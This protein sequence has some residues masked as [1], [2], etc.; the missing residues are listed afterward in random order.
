M[1]WIILYSLSFLV[2]PF[3]I[4]RLARRTAIG[5]VLSEVV[6]CYM[7]GILI[8]N[9]APYWL[10]AAEAEPIQN[11]TRSFTEVSVLL[12][13]PILL[14]LNYVLDW[15]RYTGPLLWAFGISCLSMALASLG[16]AWYFADTLPE[17][18]QAAGMLTGVFIG[19]TP[20]MVSIQRGLGVDEEVFLMLNATDTFCSGLYVI[21]LTA[22]GQHFF[23]LLLPPFRR[24]A[25]EVLAEAAL[26]EQAQNPS[27]TWK[28]ALWAT[29]ISIVVVAL[30]LA[31]GF[32]LADAEGKPNQLA[33]MLLLTA[34]GTLLS[35]SSKIRALK[36]GAEPWG[37][38]LLLIF[39]ISIGSMADFVK[40]MSQGGD[41]LL[42]TAMVVYGGLGL[43][44]L[45]AALARIDRDT[46]II[47][48]TAGIFG[49]PFV[50]QVGAAIRNHSLIAGGMALGVAGLAL[51]NYLGFALA[52][53]AKYLL[54]T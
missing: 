34:L 19:G 44:W 20:N 30:A 46:F 49:P 43:A 35:L 24:S 39:A 52:Q 15:L 27:G 2:L 32:G 23:G 38:Y 36:P 11:L 7:T 26:E 1:P 29:L 42:F 12:A 45:L 50:S 54:G 9:T 5:K 40:L 22:F 37:N 16:A 25:E 41:Y 53:L 28:Q 18:H 14:M 4:Q 8:G 13:I 51:G 21:G 3:F 10:P 48:T 31:L 17:V 6:L 33:V 47:A